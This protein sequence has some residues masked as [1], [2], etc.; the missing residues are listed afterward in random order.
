MRFD[1]ALELDLGRSQLQ[2]HEML[3]RLHLFLIRFEFGFNSVLLDL[4]RF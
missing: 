3:T 1:L 4:I 2:F